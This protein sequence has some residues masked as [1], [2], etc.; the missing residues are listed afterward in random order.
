MP[1]RAKP[2][3]LV[4]DDEPDIRIILRKCLER[5]DYAV[6]EAATGAEALTKAMEKRPDG[7][8]M[9]QRLPDFAGYEVHLHLVQLG[10]RIPTALM[11]GYP[12]V[13]QLARASGI[14]HFIPKPIAYENITTFI[15]DLL[16]PE[17]P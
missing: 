16:R 14:R 9:D 12:G 17:T 13:D 10:V 1:T 5:L 2:L 4:V 8:L 7:I 11:S 3:I 15:A 6:E